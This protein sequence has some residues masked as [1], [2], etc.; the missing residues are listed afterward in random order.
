MPSASSSALVGGGSFLYNALTEA[1][2]VSKGNG[3]PIPIVVCGNGRYRAMQVGDFPG[4]RSSARPSSP[5]P[6]A[7]QCAPST[8]GKT[9]LLNFVFEPISS[10]S[11]L[12]LEFILKGLGDMCGI[13]ARGVPP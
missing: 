1:L 10:G 3:L 9:A 13:T 2:G 4:R 5:T 11:L 12:Y 7:P 8:G 6:S